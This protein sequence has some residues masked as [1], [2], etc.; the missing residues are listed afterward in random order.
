MN[1]AE[2]AQEDK[3]VRALF[4]MALLI[5]RHVN[6]SP[7]KTQSEAEAWVNESVHAADLMITALADKKP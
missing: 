5:A 6:R 4:A 3:N 7:P 2:K 1:K